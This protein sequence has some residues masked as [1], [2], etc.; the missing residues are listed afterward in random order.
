MA[1][2]E[3]RPRGFRHSPGRAERLF[4]L[5]SVVL[6]VLF[7]MGWSWSIARARASGDSNPVT[8]A[9][10]NISTALTDGYAHSVAY[11]TDAALTALVAPARG[12]S[13]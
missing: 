3:K 4:N 9:T 8:P 6:L 5:F 10:A 2:P 7:A 11:L 13:G 12:E 1:F